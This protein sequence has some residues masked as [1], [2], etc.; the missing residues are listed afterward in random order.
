MQSGKLRHQVQVWKN[1]E[2]QDAEGQTT[3]T[4]SLD[5]TRW[6]QVEPLAGREFM[7]AGK[8]EARHTHRIKMRYYDSSFNSVEYYIV[9]IEGTRTLEINSIADIM[10]KNWE[11]ELMCTE[12]KGT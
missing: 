4:P 3:Y 10:E 6:A 1:T 12:V 8:M 5:G 9:L 11:L 2:G 7:E